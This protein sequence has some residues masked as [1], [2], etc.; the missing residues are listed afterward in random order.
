MK[1]SISTHNRRARQASSLLPKFWHIWAMCCSNLFLILFSR[2]LNSFLP[3]LLWIERKK[4]NKKAFIAER[5]FIILIFCSLLFSSL[6][7]SRRLTGRLYLVIRLSPVSLC[8]L[9]LHLTHFICWCFFVSSVSESAYYCPRSKF[10]LAHL[11]TFMDV[12]FS[13]SFYFVYIVGACDISLS[14]YS[15]KLYPYFV[16]QEIHKL[17]Y[18]HAQHQTPARSCLRKEVVRIICSVNKYFPTLN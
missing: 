18:I 13:V 7:S 17:M 10:I 5:F 2:L 3:V 12:A 8:V 4:I 9:L 6:C 15:P 16:S 14:K 1:L 11:R